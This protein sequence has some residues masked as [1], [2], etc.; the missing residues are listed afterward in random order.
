ME[1]TELIEALRDPDHKNY[2]EAAEEAADILEKMNEKPRIDVVLNEVLD[3]A[4]APV[5]SSI[6]A[7]AVLE[8][9]GLGIS[10]GIKGYGLCDMADG[11]GD[12]IIVE[13]HDGKPRLVVWAD[14]DDE[15]PTH[16]IGLE[17][18]LESARTPDS[19]PFVSSP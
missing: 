17:D 6:E 16:I 1:H 8:K 9:D 15:N 5:P 4:D 3:P 12:P 13:F 19:F 2:R 7:H 14:I 10:I 11:T 18:A